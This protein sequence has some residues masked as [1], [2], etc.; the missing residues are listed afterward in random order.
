MKEVKF[1]IL[2][3]QGE[4]PNIICRAHILGDV[5]SVLINVY[6]STITEKLWHVIWIIAICSR[7]YYAGKRGRQLGGVKLKLSLER[8]LT[9]NIWIT[10]RSMVWVINWGGTWQRTAIMVHC[11]GSLWWGCIP[12]MAPIEPS[13]FW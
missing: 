9:A 2:K 12:W 13:S 1:N 10:I 5:P 6:W 3:R 4:V 8:E 11:D 7:K